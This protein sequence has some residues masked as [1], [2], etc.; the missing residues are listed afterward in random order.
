MKTKEN[1]DTGKTGQT[2]IWIMNVNIFIQWYHNS[3]KKKLLTKNIAWIFGTK[4]EDEKAG[5]H[6][7]MK[8]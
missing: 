7:Q 1:R 3:N 8:P 6:L 4:K 5:W 2:K